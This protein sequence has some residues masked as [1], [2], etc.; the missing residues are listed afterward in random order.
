[1]S[2]KTS[3][4]VVGEN[5][6]ASKVQKAEEAGVL[7]ID[8]IPPPAAP[9][10]GSAVLS[11]RFGRSNRTWL[12]AAHTAV[13]A[14]GGG[15]RGHYEVTEPEDLG[16]EHLSQESVQAIVDGNP[17]P[18][19][20]QLGPAT[21]GPPRPIPTPCGIY[22]Q[23]VPEMFNIHALEH[24]AVIFYYRADMLTAD[25]DEASSKSWGEN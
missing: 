16:V 5:P 20:V 21:S 18:T 13:V 4:L 23:E 3:S 19:R 9:G 10:G 25:E 24:G 14:C 8:E 1:M 12:M 7:T 15:P 6:G 2:K 11:N 22:R 17:R